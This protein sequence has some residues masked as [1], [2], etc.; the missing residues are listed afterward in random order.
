MDVGARSRLCDDRDDLGVYLIEAILLLALMHPRTDN[1][2]LVVGRA[3]LTL[4]EANVYGPVGDFLVWFSL[5][6]CHGQSRAHDTKG[7]RNY[8]YKT[9][10]EAISAV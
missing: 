4:K 1:L 2:R 7:K 5:G 6:S 9:G 8:L 3:E 10:G